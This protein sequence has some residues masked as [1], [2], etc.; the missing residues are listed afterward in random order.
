MYSF[1][2][3]LILPLM[4]SDWTYSTYYISGLSKRELENKASEINAYYSSEAKENLMKLK[5]RIVTEGR[6]G[7]DIAVG[8]VTLPRLIKGQTLNYL[9]QTFVKLYQSLFQDSEEVFPNKVLFVCD[10][11]AGPGN[12]TEVK[13]LSSLCDVSKRFPI[14]DPSAVI[15]D[16]YEKEK[17]DYAFCIDMALKYQ[18]QYVLIVEDD[19]IPFANMLKVL[20]VVLNRFLENV[21]SDGNVLPGVEEWAYLK[22]YYPDRWKGFA[23]EVVPLLELLGLGLIGGS[24]FVGFGCF[25]RPKE[26]RY[27]MVRVPFLLGFIY[28]VL[29][30]LSVGRQ[31]LINWR[32]ISN[33]TY[34]V[35]PAP[36][37]CSPAILY[38]AD[39]AKELSDY[40]KTLKCSATFPIDY[41]IDQFARDGGY[42]KFLIEPN[43]VQHIGML[44]T[45]K[46]W[47][48]HPEEFIYRY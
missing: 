41:A 3:T 37:C 42:S 5:P 28:L 33:C 24:L 43:L 17:E 26:K 25:C 7:S 32:R 30:A 22:L 47:S 35:L 9:T 20:K 21:S 2:F 45:L 8:I 10:V 12:H 18:P 11:F 46:S 15:M 31:H 48:L 39:K 40:L 23:F 13:S 29:V 34:T 6:I 36:N 38:K 44:S 19:A 27:V 4:C 14:N 1:T 16:N